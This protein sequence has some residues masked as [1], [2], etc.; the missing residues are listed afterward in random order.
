VLI[1]G[2]WRLLRAVGT[3]KVRSTGML[4]TAP[5]PTSA[6]PSPPSARPAG[7]RSCSRPN[8]RSP[9]RQ[10]SSSSPPGTTPNPGPET[11]DSRHREIFYAGPGRDLTS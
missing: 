10:R 3:A 11:Q 7:M 5:G 2:L 1:S 8:R 9:P 4:R 6:R